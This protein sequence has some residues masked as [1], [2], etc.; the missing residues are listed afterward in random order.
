VR[1]GEQLLHHLVAIALPI[2]AICDRRRMDDVRA[3]M[4]LAQECT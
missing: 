2:C 3:G 4:I 1:T